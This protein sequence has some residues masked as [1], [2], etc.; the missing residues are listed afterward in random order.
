[1][2]YENEWRLY[3]QALGFTIIHTVVIFNIALDFE[4]FI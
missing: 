3:R 4:F 1:M 2:R